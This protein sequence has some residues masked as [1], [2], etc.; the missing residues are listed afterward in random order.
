MRFYAEVLAMWDACGKLRPKRALDADGFVVVNEFAIVS[1]RPGFDTCAAAVIRR[2]LGAELTKL[3]RRILV[4]QGV[5]CRHRAAFPD[6]KT[7]VADNI[8]IGRV[9]QSRHSYRFGRRPKQHPA[10]NLIINAG[11]TITRVSTPLDLVPLPK[12]N[13]LLPCKSVNWQKD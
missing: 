5:A 1:Y 2:G 12:K 8:Y 6:G 7:L 4:A 11:S 13:E 10:S 3:R 9:V